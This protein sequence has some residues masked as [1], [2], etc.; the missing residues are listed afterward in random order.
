MGNCCGAEQISDGMVEHD[1]EE[2]EKEKLR[3]DKVE[4][5]IDDDLKRVKHAEEVYVN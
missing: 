5:R 1:I 3:L 2:V 4:H